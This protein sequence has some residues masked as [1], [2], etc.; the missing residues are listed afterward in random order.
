MIMNKKEKNIVIVGI[1]YVGL[2]N[3][4]TLAKNNNVK[5]L[6]ICKNKIDLINKKISPIDNTEFKTALKSVSLSA[7]F[8]TADEYKKVDYVLIATPTNYLEK[9]KN[10]IQRLLKQP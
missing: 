10:L 8:N 2:S 1:G 5:L 7:F 9:E 3:A 4:I 6:D